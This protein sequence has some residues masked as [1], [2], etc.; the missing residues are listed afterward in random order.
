MIVTLFISALIVVLLACAGSVY[1][2]NHVYT[3]IITVLQSDNVDLRSR[4]FISRGQ[5][6][7]GVDLT[8]QYIEK[9]EEQKQDKPK[10]KTQGPLE[11][12]VSKWTKDD[13]KLAEKLNG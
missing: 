11:R 10:R 12:V 8:E 5:A 6:P 7:V 2:V 9:R 4:L 13:R 3:R 1:I